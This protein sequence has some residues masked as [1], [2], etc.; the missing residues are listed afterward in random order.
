MPSSHRFSTRFYPVLSVALFACDSAMADAII[1]YMVV[2][3]GQLL[4]LPLVIVLEAFVLQ[5]VLRG[6]FR[7][8]LFQSFIANL[9]STALGAISFA[10]ASE[11]LNS[12]VFNWWFKGG[13]SEE[14]VRSAVIS[15]GFAV[16]LWAISWISESAVIAKLRKEPISK[17]VLTACAWANVITYALLLAFAVWFG[18]DP[19]SNVDDHIDRSRTSRNVASTIQ[20]DPAYP[21]AGF[22]KKDCANDF[23]LAIEAAGNGRYSI[24]FCGPGA[25]DKRDQSTAI[26]FERDSHYRILD[27]NTIEELP[28]N[29]KL[30]RCP[31]P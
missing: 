9:V 19:S 15:L 5:K 3:W 17:S 22:W 16:V 30:L 25:C 23:G 26:D 4:L 6:R 21:M 2:P 11:F 10:L 8:N 28:E 29:S 14:S 31:T 24:L 20:N 27:P 18:Q 12:I 1:P 13:F 7:A